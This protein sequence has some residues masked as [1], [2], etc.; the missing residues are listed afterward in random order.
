VIGPARYV[1]S[2]HEGKVCGKDE[3]DT[4][5]FKGWKNV[6]DEGKHLTVALRV[7]LNCEATRGM[8]R[9]MARRFTI[10]TLSS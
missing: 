8:R 5:H 3:E 2:Y 1:A 4:C 10:S 9:F 6:L 7:K